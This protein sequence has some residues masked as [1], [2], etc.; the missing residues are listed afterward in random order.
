MTKW[1]E[2][3]IVCEEDAAV[4]AIGTQVAVSVRT[5]EMTYEISEGTSSPPSSPVRALS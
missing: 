5:K 4:E 2:T 1:T 3:E